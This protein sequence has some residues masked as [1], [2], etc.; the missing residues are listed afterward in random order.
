MVDMVLVADDPVVPS[1]AQPQE[2]TVL[3]RQV[4]T[5]NKVIVASTQAIA[6]CITAFE[7]RPKAAAPA[8]HEAPANGG[9]TRRRRARN[10]PPTD[11]GLSEASRAATT[12]AVIKENTQLV[13]DLWQSLAG[14][15]YF[16]RAGFSVA[17]DLSPTLY[18]I[19]IL[20]RIAGVSVACT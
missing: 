15:K 9:P 7:N 3:L 19:L 5:S 8:G 13:A 1:A 20:K 14:A 6:G 17:E 11:M 12:S 16:W 10:G 18:V 4:L 2:V